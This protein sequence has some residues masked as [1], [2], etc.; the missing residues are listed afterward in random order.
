MTELYRAEIENFM[1]TE[2]ICNNKLSL[3]QKF[4]LITKFNES[5]KGG[6]KDDN[7]RT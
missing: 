7:S 3:Q 6:D 1:I 2:V 5:L 4:D